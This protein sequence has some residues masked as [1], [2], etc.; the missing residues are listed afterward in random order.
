MCIYVASP[1]AKG[2][3]ALE[4]CDVGMGVSCY[5]SFPSSL[6]STTFATVGP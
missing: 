1:Y 3:G 4:V 2:E 5:E 6:S